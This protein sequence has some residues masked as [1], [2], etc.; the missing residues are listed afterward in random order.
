MLLLR[1]NLL[2]FGEKR[3]FRGRLILKAHVVMI[4]AHR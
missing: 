1:E 4:D 3:L 2:I